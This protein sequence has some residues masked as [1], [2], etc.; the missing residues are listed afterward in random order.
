MQ[1]GW[2]WQAMLSS[3]AMCGIHS[4]ADRH[5]TRQNGQCCICFM[6][7]VVVAA[8]SGPA[9]MSACLPAG[10]S[11][12]TASRPLSLHCQHNHAHLSALLPVQRASMEQAM[13][14]AHES[15]QHTDMLI[16][17]AACGH[18]YLH[19]GHGAGSCERDP[20]DR[21]QPDQR[22]WRGCGA[23]GGPGEAQWSP[24]CNSQTVTA[25]TDAEGH[26]KAQAHIMCSGQL[27]CASLLPQACQYPLGTAQLT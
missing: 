23:A 7:V 1:R 11:A 19:A 20:G 18:V 17:P 15:G 21:M 14:L 10:Q 4:R 6:G 3:A 27:G 26:G 8:G 25:D 13:A 5:A 24:I 22:A 16:C 9:A 12:F 2:R